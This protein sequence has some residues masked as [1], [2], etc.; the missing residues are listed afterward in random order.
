MNPLQEKHPSKDWLRLFLLLLV[1]FLILY[2]LAKYF[3]GYG[4]L[5]KTLHSANWNW[6]ALGFVFLFINLFLA[7]IRWFFILRSTPY[8]LPLPQVFHAFIATWPLSFIT[9]SRAGVLFRSYIIRSKV[10]LPVG[11]GSVLLA[12]C[13][14]I[15]SISILAMAGGL[16]MGLWQF[17]L[18]GLLALM[19]LWTFIGLMIFSMDTV[20]SWRFLSK[21]KDK[22]NDLLVV[23]ELMLRSPLYFVGIGVIS[24]VLWLMSIGLIAALLY[25]FGFKLSLNYVLCLW[26]IALFI[27]LLPITISGI[28]TRDLAFYSLL[29]M[30]QYPN[31]EK[32]KAATMVS[33]SFYALL[34]SALLALIGLPFLLH[35]LHQDRKTQVNSP[36]AIDADHQNQMDKVV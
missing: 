34:V 11:I 29:W 31:L 8:P 3:V 21:F 1:T 2:V 28:G 15:Q 24:L 30:V 13:L 35:F 22:A 25:G 6:I 9:P 14:D 27:G 12:K 17:A 4:N 20:M 23:F 26:P 32:Y 16:W 5:Y 10:P 33:S 36:F 19:G 18:F 7:G